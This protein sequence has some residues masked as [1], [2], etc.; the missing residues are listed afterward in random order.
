MS[1]YSHSSRVL[2]TCHANADF[3]AFA[4]LIAASFLYPNSQLLFSGTQEKNLQK[5]YETCDHA[6][7]RFIER[8]SIDWNAI[9]LLVTVDTRQKSRL[10][11]VQPLLDRPAMPIHVWDHHPA[12]A[13]DVQ[14]SYAVVEPVGAC[15]TLLVR[16]LRALPSPPSLSPQDATLIGLG[17]YG[18]TGSF[19]FSSTCPEDFETAAWLLLRGMDTNAIAE[20]ALPEMTSL[21]IHALNSLLESAQHYTVKGLDVII[22][23]VVLDDYMGDFAQLAHRV[24]EMEK[25]DALF[26]VGQMADR[27][28]VVARSRK[29]TL[30]VGSIC[31]KLGGGGHAY[32]ASA[33]VRDR[34]LAEITSLIFQELCAQESPQKLARDYMSAPAIGIESTATVH[35]ADELM[36]HFGLKAVPVFNPNTRH[37]AGIFDAQTAAR[38]TGHGLGNESVAVYMQRNVLTISPEASLQSITDT[39]IGA[40]QRLVPVVEQGE[41]KGVVTRTDLI[42]IFADEPAQLAKP[43]KNPRKERNLVKMLQ[44]KLPRPLRALLQTVGALGDALNMPVYAVGGFVRDLLMD[45][46]NQDI[47]LVV[48]GDGITFARTLAKELGGRVREHHK[49]LTAVVLWHDENQQEQHVD[50]ATARLEYYQ[51]PAALPTVELSSIKMDLFRRDFT[52]NA[53]AIRLSHGQFGRLVDFFGGQND[54]RRKAITVLHTLSFVEDPTRC[55]RAVR[56][57]QRYH[58]S[59][60]GG[61]ER[62]FKNA[63]SLNLMERL[64]GARL[65]HEI[66]RICMEEN[67]LACFVRLHE[68]GLLK[69]VSPHL[70]LPPHKISLLENL[71]E[72]M[73]WYHLL[74]F[75]EQPVPWLVYLLGL[76]RL[77]SYPEA[78]A[79]L[80]RLGLPLAQRQDFL[81]LREHLRRVLPKVEQWQREVEKQDFVRQKSALYALLHGLPIEGLL[82]LMAKS[83]DEAMRRNVSRYITQW[84]TA[85]SDISGADIIA[86]GVPSGPRVGEIL[87][88]V[89]A[90]KIDDLAPTRENQLQWAA[91]LATA[92]STKPNEQAQQE[93]KEGKGKFL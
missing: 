91:T 29:E 39:I 2:I 87:Q 23:S 90:A 78:M 1:L 34:T 42:N 22:A 51:Y 6:R 15:V 28:Q 38:A 77:L 8:D 19:T 89:L 27:V 24:L 83:G 71:Q 69:A 30:N 85:K 84:R 3:D 10:G 92:K 50:V 18:D 31:A 67:P 62:L 11:H 46:P 72:I 81:Q 16:A 40:R 56:F 44:D 64:S 66:Q 9:D 33:S 63:L 12:T 88:Q 73:D 74:Y 61:T 75:D 60:N 70:D 32:A 14:P 21:H 57:E 93:A 25:V 79:V 5:Q 59:L 13:G 76:C 58:F 68:L 49:F 45:V 47:D 48:E 26:A 37:C 65:F 53:L 86:L 55:L 41:V 52:I 35:E 82:Y 80:E 17:L 4:A 7:Y 36:L 54:L 43:E 20:T